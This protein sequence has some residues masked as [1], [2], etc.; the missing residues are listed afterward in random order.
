MVSRVLPPLFG[1]FCACASS[2]PSPP[3]PTAGAVADLVCSSPLSK[4]TI[5]V[6]S[7]QA[8]L[9]GESFE[10]DY[11][12]ER[13]GAPAMR[14]RF[15]GVR[16]RNGYANLMAGD[17]VFVEPAQGVGLSVD[18]PVG[19]E[20]HAIVKWGNG[21]SAADDTSTCRGPIVNALH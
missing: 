9:S 20:A 15:A 4:L 16:I 3:A 18:L 5:F 19:G 2:Q 11:V 7:R 17:N 10:A 12:L 13:P 21:K 14:G 1:L 8:T 6:R